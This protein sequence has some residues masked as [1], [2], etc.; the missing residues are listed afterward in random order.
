MIVLGTAAAYLGAAFIGLVVLALIEPGNRGERG[1]G[2]KLALGFALGSGIIGFYLFYLGVLQIPFTFFS[3][4]GVLWPFLALSLLPAGRRGWKGFLAFRRRCLSPPPNWKK[5]L[6]VTGIGLLLAWRMFFAVFGAL[7]IPTYFDDSVANYNFKPKVFYHTGSIVLDPE[8][9]LFLGGYRPAYPQQLPLFKVWV[10]TWTGGWNEP[11]V[12]LITP[13]IYLCLGLTAWGFFR[14]RLAGTESLIFTYLILSLP[15]LAFHSAFAYMD[16]NVAF[17]LFAA[18]GCL[19]DWFRRR[20]P[21]DFWLSALLLGI[22]LSTKDEMLALGAAGLLPPLIL[23]LAVSR[24]RWPQALGKAGLYL[25]GVLCANIPWFILKRLYGLAV[26]PRPEERCFE[27]HPEAFGILAGFLL[28]TGNYNILWPVFIGGVLAGAGLLWKSELKY[29]LLS[30]LGTLAITLAL[31]ICT[32]FFEF[33]RI[34]TTI[35]RAMMI[36]APLA[37]FYLA[38]LYGLL[39]AKKGNQDG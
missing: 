12:N 16:I 28:G 36:V 24:T 32:P 38:V 7:H 4:T 25:T 5:R 13:L 18:V 19:L 27:F 11:S 26:G 35:N 15:L 8:S 1:V 21:G 37:V 23:Y 2:E 10:M 20:Q 34:G 17:Y 22:G 39:T 33:L 6:L 14:R 9:P 29:L 3:V 30:L 31:F